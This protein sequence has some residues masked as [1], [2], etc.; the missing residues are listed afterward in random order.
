MDGRVFVWGSRLTVWLLVRVNEVT[1]SV[2]VCFDDVE[3]LG[4][5][6]CASM[7]TTKNAVERK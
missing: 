1:E 6:G 7:S 2:W 5:I 3:R 4:V